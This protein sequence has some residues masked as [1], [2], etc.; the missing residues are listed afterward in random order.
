M[1]EPE[2]IEPGSNEAQDL[3]RSHPD[4]RNKNGDR[5]GCYPLPIGWQ[6]GQSGNPN[7]RPPSRP[8]RAALKNEVKK[9]IK[10][11]DMTK[12][13]GIAEALVDEALIGNVQAIRE[14]RDTLEGKPVQVVAGDGENPFVQEVIHTIVH[15]AVK[16]G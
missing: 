15:K 7:G 16:H 11:K 2:I 9:A 3:D 4:W 6:P 12:L 13:E 14:V 8:F 10:A 1:E 5:R